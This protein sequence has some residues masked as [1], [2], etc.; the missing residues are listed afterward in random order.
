MNNLKRVVSQGFQIKKLSWL[1]SCH[2][3]VLAGVPQSTYAREYFNPSL[4]EVDNPA[5]PG[6]DLSMFEEGEQAPGKYR[7]DILVND[8]LIDT[9]DVNF[10]YQADASG[11]KSLQ[12]CFSAEELKSFGVKVELFPALKA[13]DQCVNLPGAI[14][15]ASSDF[16]FNQQRLSLSIPQ[17]AM[18]NKARGYV[19]PKYWDEGIVAA[20]VNYN[21]SG[22][23]SYGRKPGVLDEHTYYLNLRSGLNIGPWRLRN[24]STWSHND[25]NGDHWNSINTYVERSIIPLKARLTMGDSSSQSDV[26]DSVSFRGAQ[27]ASDD[28]MLPDSLKGFAPVVRGIARTNA[29]V[30]VRQNGYIIY[31]TYVPAGAFVINDLYPTSGSGDLFVNIK[32]ADGSEQNMV[33]PYASVPILQRPGRFKFSITSGQY[34]SFDT[35]VD[36]TP[37]SQATGIYGLRWG[38]TLYGGFQA[39]SKYQSLALGWG[40]NLGRLGA[41]SADVTQAWANRS[42]N[43]KTDGQSWRVRFGKN[44]I[45]TGTNFSLA[46]YRYSTKGFYTLKETLDTYTDTGFASY[47]DHKKSRAEL[48]I[49]QRLGEHGG[50]LTASLVNETYWNNAK[51]MES[52]GIGYNNYWKSISYSL[53]YTYTK[54][55]YDSLLGQRRAYTD[56]IFNFTVSVPLSKFLPNGNISYALN[57]SKQGHTNN[58]VSLYGTALEGRNLTYNI[59]QSYGSQGDGASGNASVDYRGGMGEVNVGY[60]YD[61][62]RHRVNYGVQG[63]VLVHRDG[64]TLSQPLNETTILV[65]APGA[66]HARLAN[67]TGVT[68]DWRGYAVIPYAAEYRHNE[69][70]F[71]TKSLGDNVDMVQTTQDVIPTRGAVVRADF[72]A[73]VGQRALLTLLMQNGE[74]VP[75]GAIVSVPDNKANSGGIVGDAGQVYM[76]GLASS[77]TLAVKWGN[78]PSQQCHVTYTLGATPAAGIQ[79]ANA[80]CR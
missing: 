18:D 70:R 22:S 5:Q 40:Q 23:N 63:G 24:Y 71:D 32:E 16:D 38:A 35:H 59:S 7:V 76:S 52:Y 48:T 67:Q 53:N 77:G 11:E 13:N 9:R 36:K 39:S 14:P 50:S 10:T 25:G 61:H 8:Q 20:M 1:V 12:P 3:L 64:I 69:I 26:F 45:N 6:V 37:F 46:S 28:D 60:S 41:I 49:G 21:F 47:Q 30:T 74:P 27:L 55:G 72:K 19:P 15:H 58:T 34:R 80:Q 79:T 56:S 57:T 62:D 68:T 65:K 54:N 17:I 66:A 29:T 4:L 2:L 73:N 43:L 33:V 44:F 51:R 75:F 78:Q 42:G 31:Q